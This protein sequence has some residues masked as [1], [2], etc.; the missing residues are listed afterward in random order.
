M[1]TSY[2]AFGLA[3][4]KALQ[5]GVR[6]LADAVRVTL[7]PAGRAVLIAEDGKPP[8]LTSDGARVAQSIELADRFADMGARLVRN[9]AA[10]TAGEAGDGRTTATVIAA[11]LIEEGIGAVAAGADPVAL[12]RAIEANV[13]VVLDA[14]GAAARPVEPGPALER[15]ATVAANGDAEI[16]GIVARAVAATGEDGVVDVEPGRGRG[17]AC[18]I[19]AGVR[20][21]RGYVSPYFMTDPETLLCTYEEPLILL[22]DG[23]LD[24]HEPLLRL[25]EEAVRARRPLVIVAEAVE[26]EALRTLAANKIRGGLSLV[27][28][29]APHFGDRR[30]AALE[31]AAVLTGATVIADDKGLALQN[32]GPGFLGSARRAVIS[33][34]ETLFVEGA[35]E[36]AAVEDRRREIRSAIAAAGTEY[37]RKLLGE[38]L[39]LL[40]GGVASIGIG[41]DS[42]AEIADRS[43]RARSAARAARA[44]LANGVVAGGGAALLHAARALEGAPGGAHARR[45]LRAGLAAPLR[46][47]ADNAGHDGRAVAARLEEARDKELGFD[48]IAGEIRDMAEAGI[49][50]PLDVTAAALRHAASVAG[51]ILT[52]EAALARPP[53]PQSGEPE[54]FGP[55]TP[56]FGA[57]EL[58]GLGLA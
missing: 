8:F 32:A 37:D 26:G 14:L 44:A 10:R 41:G 24:R 42:E 35:G 54:G 6:T 23:R 17:I 39:A 4:R 34:G 18:E 25:L 56:D 5:A 16:G 15:V 47:I 46:Q 19:V 27:A 2:L 45:V 9:A 48:A 53:P 21:D 33:A 55:T 31:D 30:R 57:D 58:E 52:A 22:Y 51:M 43:E 49:Q 40:A 28:A 36:P 1:T 3:G 29:T 20:F 11:A 12:K 7:G 38:R 50:D 13:T